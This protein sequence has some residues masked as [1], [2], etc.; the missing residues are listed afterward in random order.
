MNGTKK[1]TKGQIADFISDSTQTALDTRNFNLVKD[2][3]P[4]IAVT[5]TTSVTQIGSSILIPANTFSANDYFS[6][7]SFGVAK[8]GVLGTSAYRFL[9]NTSDTLT[10]ATLLARSSLIATQITSNMQRIFEIEGGLIK[11]RMGGS[12]NSFTDKT[13]S[14][15]AGLSASFDPTIDNYFFTAVELTNA[16]DSVIRTQIVITK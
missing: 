3:T 16:T 13:A 8:T 9:T 11:C 14:T 12:S 10:G 15:V 5:G 6:L 7:D 4:T 1:I 2:S